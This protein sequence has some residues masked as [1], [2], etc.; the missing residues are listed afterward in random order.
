[1]KFL[2]TVLLFT[3]L[4]A[5]FAFAETASDAFI[6][7]T[8]GSEKADFEI[9]NNWQALAVIA[10]VLSSILVAIAYMIGTGFEMPELQAWAKTEFVQIITNAI[11]ILA[12][13]A[14]V[15]FVN[16]IVLSVAYESDL[17]LS[18]C[19]IGT[20]ATG[21]VDCLKAVTSNYL[22]TQ[23]TDNIEKSAKA[24]LKSNTKDSAWA[25]RRLGINCISLVYCVQLG[26]NMGFWGHYALNTDMYAIVFE[27]YTNLL[28]FIGAQRFFVEEISFKMAPAVLAVG[29]VARS[30][31]FTRKLGGLLMAIAI[32]CMFFFPGM[33]IFDWVTLDMATNG[34]PAGTGQDERNCPAECLI[35]S[36]LVYSDAGVLKTK[37]DVYLAFAPEDNV[38]AKELIDGTRDFAAATTTNSS[39][40]SYGKI[41]KSCN[42]IALGYAACPKVCRELPYPPTSDCVVH[43]DTAFVAKSCAMLP[44]ACKVKRLVPPQNQDATQS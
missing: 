35:P 42:S 40:P 7:H 22:S 12:L 23:I 1:M 11:I 27:H 29:I 33:Y 31:F 25:A 16:L 38:T 15:V 28:A 21:G 30:F 43:N 24:V 36:P 32:G 34:D 6:D 13:F 14:T 39:S 4:L 37:D 41:L 20:G 3:I 18:E 44:E 10:L 5:T 8:T 2:I 26:I 17:G 9:I 19:N